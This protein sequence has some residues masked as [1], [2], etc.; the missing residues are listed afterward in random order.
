MT[1]Q[2][3]RF[4]SAK[5]ENIKCDGGFKA[6]DRFVNTTDRDLRWKEPRIQERKKQGEVQ[7]PYMKHSAHASRSS[8]P[9][10]WTIGQVC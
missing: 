5:P 4:V 7:L 10:Y 6:T 9:Q 3:V 1:P 8:A 2:K